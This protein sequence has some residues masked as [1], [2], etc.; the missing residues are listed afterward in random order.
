MKEVKIKGLNRGDRVFR[1]QDG[2]LVK[3]RLADVTTSKGLYESGVISALQISGSLVGTD[4]K[5]HRKEGISA[6]DVRKSTNP[7]S[8]HMVN[9]PHVITVQKSEFSDFDPK[10]AIEKA[11]SEH[12][13]DTVRMG[14]Q[15]KAM[16]MFLKDWQ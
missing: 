4:G 5:A 3:I 11:I 8:L 12:I 16:D 6:S 10:I 9:Q 14:Q 2:V 15:V 7:A 1:S 13:E